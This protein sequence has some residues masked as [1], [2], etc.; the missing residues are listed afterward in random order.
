MPE[1]NIT[2]NQCQKNALLRMMAFAKSPSRRVFILKGYAGTGKTTLVKSLIKELDKAKIRYHLL[3]STG[4]AA[5]ILANTTGV[6]QTKTVH[7]LIYKYTGFSED[8]DKIV[9]ER[10]QTGMDNSGQLWITFGLSSADDDAHLYIIDEASMISNEEE[11]HDTQAKYENGRLLENILSY[12]DQGKFIFVGDA[13]QLPPINQTYSPALSVSFFANEFEIDAEEAELTEIVR[14]SHGNDIAESAQ[15]LRHLCHSPQATVWAKFPLKGYHNIHLLSSTT[16]L[17]NRYLKDI[18]SKGFNSVTMIAHSNK[19]C[20]TTTEIIR[21]ALGKTDRICVGDLL[22]IT[23]NNR[24][25]KL[26]NG[27]LVEV[28]AIDNCTVTRAGLTFIQVTVKELFT[29]RTDSLYMILE[30][31]LSGRTNLTNVQHKS[32]FI[33]FAIRMKKKGIMQKDPRFEDA[34]LVDPFLNALRCVYGYVLTTHKAQGGEWDD[35][36]LDIPRYL[37]RREKPFVYQWVYTAMTRAKKELYVVDDFYL[38]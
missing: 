24:V 34:M 22:L 20:L 32:L 36:Y 33:D 5:K 2:L 19:Q 30:V 8:L 31:L 10:E 29:G 37:S 4:R 3:A 17:L 18:R 11:L 7:G 38:I 23:Q 28:T 14:Q 1:Q 16:E 12:D 27:D 9:Q 26:M 13:C 35:V 15:R 21:H 25:A 6:P